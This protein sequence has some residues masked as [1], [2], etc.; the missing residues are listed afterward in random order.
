MFK[1]YQFRK[2]KIMREIIDCKTLSQ[3]IK[4]DVKERVD[5]LKEKGIN[6]KL[7]VLT[8][9][10][11]EPS[12]AYVRNKRKVCEEVGIRFEE[13]PFNRNIEYKKLLQVAN[14]NNPVVVQ[15]PINKDV[16]TE[17]TWE[18][19]N[20]YYCCP[21]R[22]VDG[23]FKDAFVKPATAKGVMKI[24]NEID[25]NLEGK[26]VCI[27]GRGKTCA[28]PLIQMM[29]DKNATVTICHSYTKDLDSITNPCDVIVSC[30]G[31]PHLIT[32]D[33]IKEEA[34]V[35]NVGLSVNPKTGKLTGDVDFA[36]CKDKAGYIT[37]NIG[38]VGLLTTACLAENVVELYERRL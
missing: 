4:D 9:P 26:E 22:D 14:A 24:F 32:D 17:V 13:I 7:T 3:K 27:I 18:V 12:K 21:E 31:K 19:I 8:N 11:D 23:F 16:D 33:H 36:A 35:I 10:D 30:V 25:Y 15:L 29:L 5:K 20:D 28:K 34:V 37:K 2:E 1:N 38:G 6:P